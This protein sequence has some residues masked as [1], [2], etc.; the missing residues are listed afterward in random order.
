MFTYNLA[1]RHDTGEVEGFTGT[2]LTNSANARE[3]A[4]RKVIHKCREIC[5]RDYHAEQV[6]ESIDRVTREEQA[7]IQADWKISARSNRV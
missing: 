1:Y 4:I 5:R 7:E 2:A 3:N 6:I